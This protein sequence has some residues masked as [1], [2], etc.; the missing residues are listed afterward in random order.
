MPDSSALDI[1]SQPAEGPALSATSDMPAAPPALAAVEPVKV[2]DAPTTAEPVK[3]T[4]EA[5][6][7]A[8]EPK[9]PKGVG[10]KLAEQEATIAAERAR[11]EA[12]ERRAIEAE[13]A[14]TARAK[15]AQDERIKADVRPN[16]D[17]F[18]DPD[19]YEEAL[20]AWAGRDA[21]RQADARRAEQEAAAAQ[22]RAEDAARAEHAR[23]MNEWDARKAKATAEHPD[24]EAVALRKDLPITPTM[25][26]AIVRAEDG[27]K[28]A[29]YLG[30]NA[31]EVARIAALAPGL[32]V[33]EMGRL[34]AKLASVKPE[35]SQAPA[36]INTVGSNSSALDTR[37]PGEESM[38]EYAA[39][40]T[41]QIQDERMARVQH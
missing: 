7:T 12:A 34:S 33:Y 6:E 18:T 11:A 35:V 27:A 25:A 3:A 9:E 24:F 8:V 22:A 29:Y 30:Q 17:A 23:V 36:P 14:A 37:S 5:P 10:K 39:R 21:I 16:R 26:Q 32:Q 1:I 40:R 13:A 4:P 38:D 19:T 15:E 41:K 2:S 20:T 28:V 31:E